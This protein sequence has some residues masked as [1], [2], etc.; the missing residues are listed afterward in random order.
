MAHKKAAGSTRNGRDSESKRLG[1]KRYGGE[2]VL[3]GN[4]IVRQR[5][6]KFHAGSNVGIGKDH[7]LFATAE[8]KVKFEVKGPKNRKYVSI[9]TE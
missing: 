3:A 6:T 7:T 9:I 5:G 4:I 8:G 2:S 1:V